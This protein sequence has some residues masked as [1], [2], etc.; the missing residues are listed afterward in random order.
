MQILMCILCYISH[1]LIDT[2]A[3]KIFLKKKKQKFFALFSSMSLGL[4]DLPIVLGLDKIDP[5][6]GAKVPN[7]FSPLILWCWQSVAL[8]C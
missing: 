8:A 1:Q 6:L 5:V 4:K 3:L 7:E 2:D